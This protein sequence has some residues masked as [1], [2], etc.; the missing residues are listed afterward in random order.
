MTG[1]LPGRLE[2]GLEFIALPLCQRHALGQV[3]EEGGQ[4]AL[5]KL[6]GH[7]LELRVEAGLARNGGAKHMSQ[8]RPVAKHERLGLESLEELLDRG[9]IR[10]GAPRIQPRH[11]VADRLRTEA[12]QSLEHFEF[13]IGQFWS[14]KAH[15]PSPR[16]P[17]QSD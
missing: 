9:V 8:S 13:G 1:F 4:R 11:Q 2:H 12:P 6:V 16:R 15:I 3:Q 5:A 17:R 14:T 7:F 10:R